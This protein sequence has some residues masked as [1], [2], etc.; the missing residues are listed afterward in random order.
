MGDSSAGLTGVLAGRYAIERALGRGG[1]ATVYLAQDLQHGSRVA[2]EVLRP[3]LA[4][5]GWLSLRQSIWSGV[6]LATVAPAYWLLPGHVYWEAVPFRI[7]PILALIV[8]GASG[9]TLLRRLS[10]AGSGQPPPIAPAPERV[11]RI[12]S[13]AQTAGLLAALIP[14]QLTPTHPIWW[15]VTLS[16]AIL[17]LVALRHEIWPAVMLGWLAAVVS[18]PYLVFSWSS[19]ALLLLLAISSGILSL[20]L[21]AS[22]LRV[23]R[24]RQVVGP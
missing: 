1:I 3:E 22:T 18:A 13:Y 2:V 24:R 9:A 15:T 4:S 7:E 17:A 8:A 16:G 23:L 20:L 14:Y 11:I 21:C 19:R 12:W 5:L 6:L 10:G